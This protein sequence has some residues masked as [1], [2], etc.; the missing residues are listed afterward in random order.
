V[1]VAQ[2]S[3]ASGN[4]S[5]VGKSSRSERVTVRTFSGGL[6]NTSD[7][8]TID[9][10]E[11][12]LLEN[13][14]LDA[15]GSLVSRPPIVKVSES[16]VEGENIRILGYFVTES[17]DISAII[18]GDSG[19][20]LWNTT[21]GTYTQ[22]T[23]IVASGAA[24]YRDNLYISSAEEPG[25]YWDGST[26]T[27]LNT[28]D[29]PMPLGEQLILHKSRFFLVSRSPATNKGRVY[30]SDVTTIGPE[31]TSINDWD[32]DN[33]FDVSRGDGQF[34]TK[35]LSASN[36]IFI[37]RTKS[38]YF[39]RYST[40]PIDGSLEVLDATVGADNE[41]C[42]SEYEFSYLVLNN[43][44]L[45]RFVSYQFYPLNDINRLQFYQTKPS[46]SLDVFS[47][48]TVF[49]R[50]AIVW[51]GGGTYVL[52]LESGAW[53]TW[54]SPTSEMAWG[55]LSPRQQNALTPDTI[56]GITGIVDSNFK[57]IYRAVDAYLT[58]NV[59]EITCRA[60]T[61]AFDFNIP[62]QWKRLFY[63]SADV[64]TSRDVTGVAR[65]IQFTSVINY[66]DEMENYTWDD[67]EDWVEPPE[68]ISLEDGTWDYP[69]QKDESVVTELVYPALTP[70][71]V[72]VTFQKD[73]RFRRCSFRAV[74]T[75]NGTSATGPVRIISL[76][77]HA[78]TKKGISDNIQ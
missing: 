35:I 63:W 18:S 27:Q 46:G 47:S 59:E 16:P 76:A 58:E 49:G 3:A 77:I 67:P 32:P 4:Y 66:W 74:L 52:D 68:Y 29:N 69:L 1:A 71:R 2:T 34:I 44:R 43:G 15:N 54:D 8:T 12:H 9:D 24:Q 28:G 36:E 57:G 50:R 64:Y 30:F 40:G 6:N 61:K 10:E 62:D 55:L 73:M 31:A 33:Y 21:S 26:F 13:F 72:N 11:L 45:Y 39:F 19:T 53:S 22:V 23:T 75:T 41:L 37:F 48:L 65:P 38:T 17:E 20:Y 70:Y 14:E 7:I 5:Q 51:F 60:E 56:Y 25:G 42:V 78:V